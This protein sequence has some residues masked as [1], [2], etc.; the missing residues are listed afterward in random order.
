MERLRWRHL[1]IEG[2]SP[3]GIR[4]QPVRVMMRISS[5]IEG[6]DGGEGDLRPGIEEAALLEEE[7]KG[8]GEDI[9]GKGDLLL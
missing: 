4:I 6:E 5:P 3:P 1:K 7:R 9:G 8:P 2:G